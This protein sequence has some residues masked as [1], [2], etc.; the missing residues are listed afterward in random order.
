MEK[1]FSKSVQIKDQNPGADLPKI[2]NK[3][4]LRYGPFI[5]QN[6]AAFPAAYHPACFTECLFNA[7]AKYV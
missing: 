7:R 5:S 1:Y 4:E 6:K 2:E 3:F